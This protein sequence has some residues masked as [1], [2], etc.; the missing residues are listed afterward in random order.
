[1]HCTLITNNE[2]PKIVDA[3]LMPISMKGH[4]ACHPPFSLY[5]RPIVWL[6]IGT[7]ISLLNYL[8]YKTKNRWCSVDAQFQNGAGSV[9]LTLLPIMPANTAFMNGLNQSPC[10][11]P[12]MQD[13][14]ILMLRWCSLW[15]GH[16]HNMASFNLAW[17]IING[18]LEAFVPSSCIFSFING[19]FFNNTYKDIL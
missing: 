14:K 7:T 17:Y 1:M 19:L 15:H 10:R 11:L 16:I 5:S 6:Y 3:P 12:M 18:D 2:R 4:R 9:L 13:Q 8:T